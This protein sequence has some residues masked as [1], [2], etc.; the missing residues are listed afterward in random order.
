MSMYKEVPYC[1]FHILIPSLIQLQTFQQP[2]II[3][4]AVQ[5]ELHLHSISQYETALLQFEET[6][7]MQQI[8]RWRKPML[9]QRTLHS[10]PLSFRKAAQTRTVKICQCHP[11]FH[12]LY[13]PIINSNQLFPLSIHQHFWNLVRH[14]QSPSRIMAQTKT[15]LIHR[16][17]LIILI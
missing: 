1:S 8:T 6:R 15:I 12:P 14:H 11:H 4:Q 7:V 2:Y 16:W 3:L 9:G 13:I 10:R 17:P 5:Q